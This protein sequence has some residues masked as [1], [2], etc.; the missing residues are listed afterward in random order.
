MPRWSTFAAFLSEAERAP[1]DATRQSLV[2]ALLADR[3][4]WPWVEARQAT[5]IYTQPGVRRGVALN[6]D[7]IKG[8][9]PLAPMSQLPGT[10]FWFITRAFAPDDLLDYLLAV[11]DPMT[12]LAEE[13]DLAGRVVTHWRPDPLNP[14]RMRSG[15]Q[16]VS[17]LR[18]P[19]A[20]PFPDWTAFRGVPRGRVTPTLWNSSQLH[21]KGRRV[22]VYAPPDYMTQP[23]KTYPLLVLQDGQWCSGP[24]QVPAIA[25][26]LIKHGRMSPILIAMVE[27]GEARQRDQEYLTSEHYYSA[28]MLEILPLLQ[29]RYRVDA[30]QIGIGGVSQG[31]VAA[32]TSVLK[33]P[34]VFDTL[35]MIS[36]PFGRITEG[37]LLTPSVARL[38][39]ARVLPPRIFHAVGRYENKP[40][41]L[42]P[43][44]AL[45]DVLQVR[46]DIL[47][48][49]LE[50]GSGHGLVAF[51]S[52]LPEALSWAYPAFQDNPA[53]S[54]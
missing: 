17:V 49:Y 51:R 48:R 30:G 1:D 47:Y 26:V 50:M 4:E 46:P 35:I 10:D 31:A 34:A 7:A 37:D 45:R 33:N 38:Q 52:I 5:F 2:A 32:L 40:R 11:D 13:P 20:R 36:P 42:R 54:G 41:F 9:P 25:D 24:L 21:A 15:E 3:T 28:I 22:W 6:L 18:M 39:A 43:A 27:S 12:P 23:D 14:V 29:T 53:F 44:H 19:Q 16:E 8:D